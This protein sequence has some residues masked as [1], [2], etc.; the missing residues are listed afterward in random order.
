MT[1]VISQQNDT[2]DQI[3]RRHYGRTAGVT[4]QVLDANP[5]LAERGPVIPSGVTITL[6]EITVQAEIKTVNLWD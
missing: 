5:G 4:E 1:T 3:C 2:V 6:P